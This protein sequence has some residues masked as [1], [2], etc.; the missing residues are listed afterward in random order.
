MSK[1]FWEKYQ[2]NTLA[3]F[4][5]SPRKKEKRIEGEYSVWY[6]SLAS[7]Y[8]TVGYLIETKKKKD[9]LRSS[10][11]PLRSYELIKYLLSFADLFEEK[12]IS[13]EPFAVETR[14]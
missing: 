12:D 2:K 5:I 13:L 1:A 6:C 7:S 14:S 8:L 3:R 4:S 11:F 10:T 9:Y